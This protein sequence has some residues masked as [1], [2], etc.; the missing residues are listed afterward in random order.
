M[1]AFNI[2]DFASSNPDCD[3]SKMM[4]HENLACRYGSMLRFKTCT[5]LPQYTG[6]A[7]GSTARLAAEGSC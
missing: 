3:K 2:N 1:Q 6:K 5:T 4:A 7:H